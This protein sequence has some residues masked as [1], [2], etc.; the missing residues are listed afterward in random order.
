VGGYAT[1]LMAGAMTS[2]PDS[3]APRIS[4]YQLFMLALS[5]WA[6]LTLAAGTVWQ[7]DRESQTVLD[8]A[9]NAVCGLFFIDF[10]LNLYYA[11]RRLTYLA[12]WGWVD[13]L[14]SIPV[15]DQL[16]WGRAGR[17][18]RI[19]RVLRAV[20]SVRVLGSLLVER[21]AHSA[22]LAAVLLTVLLLVFSSLAMLQFEAGGGGNIR[23]AQDAMWWAVTTMTTVGYGDTYPSTPE[24][25]L[26]AVFLMLAGIGVFGSFSGLVASWFLSPARAEA[27]SDS[28]ELK[29]MVADIQRRLPP[30]AT[31]AAS[32]E[33]PA[34]PA[35]S[36]GMLPP[37]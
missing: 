22:F 24:G 30:A 8:Y 33:T 15:V 17:I 28:A 35:A 31:S 14:S 18:L 19:L 2:S 12:T 27:E 10:L 37:V 6:L 25:R 13:L 1:T 23:T 5:I 26:V 32:G 34:P 9:D 29:A 16:R 4:P 3:T 11:P 20:K 7:F 36:A 21:R